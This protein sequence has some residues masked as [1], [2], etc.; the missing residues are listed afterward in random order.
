MTLLRTILCRLFLSIAEGAYAIA[1]LIA[2]EEVK[3]L[4]RV[5]TVSLP[6]TNYEIQKLHRSSG[7]SFADNP[8]AQQKLAGDALISF[9]KKC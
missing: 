3:R 8:D 2:P 7:I 1:D 5:L 4:R 9:V 6:E